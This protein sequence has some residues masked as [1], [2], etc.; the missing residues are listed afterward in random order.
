M[1]VNPVRTFAFVDISGFTAL[2][3]AHGDEEAVAT[4]AAIPA[5]SPMRPWPPA[6]FW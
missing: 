6:T 1:T 3:E 5:R 4:L 2:T